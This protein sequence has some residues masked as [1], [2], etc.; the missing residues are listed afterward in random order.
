MPLVIG[1]IAPVQLRSDSA[2]HPGRILAPYKR[3]NFKTWLIHSDDD[4]VTWTGDRELVN[5]TVTDPGVSY[6]DARPHCDRGMDYFGFHIDSVDELNWRDLGRFAAQL[7][8][9]RT[10]IFHRS[11]WRSKLTGAWQFVGTG[12]SKSLQ[13][14]S[15]RVVVPGYHGY[16]RGLEDDG[17]L[18]TSQL[19]SSVALGH[20]L[21]TDD[22]GD[23]WRMSDDWGEG[24]GANENEMVELHD[25]S[26]LTNSRSLSTGTP[27]FRLQARSFDQGE[28]FSPTKFTPEI[29]SPFNGAYGSTLSD[30]DRTV[31]HASPDPLPAQS[32]LQI[33]LD[34]LNCNINGTGRTRL[35]VWK[36]TTAGYTYSDK[37][38]L[39]AG[40][41]AQNSFQW[42]GKT[43][44]LLYEQSDPDPM[45]TVE[46][47]V[48]RKAVEDLT[49]QLPHRFVFRTVD[50]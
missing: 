26:V 32:Y 38:L 34:A 40:A 10:G 16:V 28:S 31:Y 47:I 43:P 42:M 12:P 50:I 23:T 37:V 45:F 15:G 5:V 20:T 33:A 46:A 1:N 35:S 25:G 44:V 36:S 13:L 29:Q 17:V 24:D 41:S 48:A 19:Y 7:C 30:G 18:P 14:R 4:G 3:N 27:Q 39:D 49:V 22:G 8:Y 9:H 2:H 6:E 21:I 11:N